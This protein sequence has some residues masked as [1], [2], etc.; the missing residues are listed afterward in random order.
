MY[1]VSRKNNNMD[2]NGAYNKEDPSL[3]GGCIGRLEDH[4]LTR[5][6]L[7]VEFYQQSRH[8]APSKKIIPLTFLS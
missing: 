1:L 4:S 6:C 8:F 7:L 5:Y 2:R 3:S